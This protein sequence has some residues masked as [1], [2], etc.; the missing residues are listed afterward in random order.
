[1]TA[2]SKIQGSEKVI[3]ILG[4][5]T[6]FHDA[7][8]KCIRLESNNESGGFSLNI[9]LG[10]S[11]TKCVWSDDIHYEYEKINEIDL[12][13]TFHGIESFFINDYDEFESVD[14]LYI[15]HNGFIFK[16]KIESR[17]GTFIFVN[18]REIKVES[19]LK[20]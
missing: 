4:E 9:S 15:D 12:L 20:K 3:E 10:Y 6:S 8:I 14:D 5:W 11:Q 1:M 19:V 2:I 18:C 7:I 16:V 17:N 13:L